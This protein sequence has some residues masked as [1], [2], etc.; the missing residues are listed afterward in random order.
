M[1]ISTVNRIMKCQDPK[2]TIIREGILLA[3]P[4][5]VK[6]LEAH[7]GQGTLVRGEVGLY[8]RSQ[9]SQGSG[10]QGL[11]FIFIDTGVCCRR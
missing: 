3:Q 7:H 5:N 4:I 10:R 6:E 1:E 11:L 8:A 9:S 2:H